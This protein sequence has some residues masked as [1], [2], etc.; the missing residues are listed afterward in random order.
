[1]EV[2]MI[3]Q[4]EKIKN[5]SFPL[6]GIGSG[7]VGLAGNG[8]FRDWE[9]FN[10]PNKHSHNGFSHFALRVTQDGRRISKVLQGDCVTALGDFSCGTPTQTMAGFPH[11]RDV[12]FDGR[13][14]VAQLQLQEENF[15]IVA[16]LTAF[17]PFIP[18]DED[19]SSLP[20]AMF[21]WELKNVTDRDAD[22][23]LGLSLQNPSTA[24]INSAFE[25]N[26]SR[27]IY[28]RDTANGADDRAYFD[29]CML[30]DGAD[31]VAEEYWYRGRWQ[32]AQSVY[33]RNF[34]DL[35][36]IPE[37]SYPTAG[38]NDHA[39]LAA[40]FN[41]PAGG[42]RRV[43]FVI[44]WNAP[45]MY[46]YW[47]KDLQES[48]R[49][50]WKNY[51]ATKFE[52]SRAT[53]EYAM[54]HYDAFYEKTK[55]FSDALQSCSLPQT[56]IDAISSNLSVLK[57]PTVFRLT[58]GSLW[59]WEG[60]HNTTGSCE[61]S[62]QHVWNYAYALPFLF[63]RLERS[64]RDVTLKYALGED[65]KSSFRIMLP[66]CR[67]PWIFRACVDG[68]MGEVIKCYREWKFSGDTNWLRANAEKIFSMLEYAWSPK[69]PDRWDA[70]MDGVMEGRQHHT[71]DMELFGPNSW[72]EGFYLLALDCGSKMAEAVGDAA[73]AE[74]YRAM[75]ENGRAWTNEHLF[76]GE[77]FCQ[78]ID[79]TDK[80]ILERFETEADQNIVFGANYW[81][82]EAGQ[83]KYQI[84]DGCIIDQ[85]LAEWHGA[86][87]GAAPIFDEDK[88]RT[89]LE[90]LYRYNYIP[91][92]RNVANMWRLFAVDD[93]AGTIICSYPERFEKPIIPIPYCE[94]VMTGFEY[95]AAGL[96]LANGYV[97]ECETMV[98][99]IRNRYDGEKRNPWDEIE[100]GHN[101]A[102]SMAS[103]ALMP[104]YSGFTFDMTKNHIG[105][106]PIGGSGK[107]LFSICQSWGT[108]EFD[109]TGCRIR[110]LGDPLTLCS[111]SV[112]NCEDITNVTVDGVDV[113]FEIFE[114]RIVL[115]HTVIRKEL[116]LK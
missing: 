97:D 64:L 27:G 8:S 81:N 113:D 67:K 54:S 90:S 53:A 25:K 24:G 43:R 72:L 98:S 42:S 47:A 45:N 10:R 74:K 102:R 30:C 101:Y 84:G 11:F 9:I 106:S 57:S 94:E 40:Y 22:C 49:G 41:I 104:I 20:V 60:V 34:T 80:G 110:M 89:A 14:P 63:P 15:P 116:L 38:K 109:S 73:R 36:R 112:P 69:N 111:I 68:Q 50:F 71:L 55:A 21:E 78:K 37:R 87:I 96:M 31:T 103:Y 18:H 58:D 52:N 65:G 92:M 17:N 93:E 83:I 66:L 13:F 48:E 77:Y 2:S 105:F 4:N 26:G 79:L 28:L 59:G 91:S 32:D 115:N 75:Y 29:L 95:A 108:V 82:A 61:G 46:N 39:T 86:M 6:G 114:K 23:V 100:C 51:Y 107:F 56:M 12:S 7:S 16:S 19:N 33:W 85:M 62:C 5:I 99:A 88:K 1:M 35:D 76:N 3:Y 44:A 70:D